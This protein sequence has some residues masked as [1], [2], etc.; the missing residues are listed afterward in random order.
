[1]IIYLNERIE[2]IYGEVAH[3]TVELRV[4]YLPSVPA[5]DYG[6]NFLNTLTQNLP[7]DLAAGFTTIGPHR[8]DFKVSFNS[9]EMMAVAS[10]GEVRTVVLAL[11]LAELHYSEEKSGQRPLLL[12]DDVFSE[13]DRERRTFL[14]DKLAGYQSV[15]TTTDAD[16][17][18]K[19]IR[20]PFSV[21]STGGI[22]A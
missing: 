15:I 11:K 5:S 21:I 14:I 12:L 2:G 1:M 8:E 3:G 22:Y 9:S 4:E 13:L 20:T 10:R 18:T 19:E 6:S 17:V 7:R 16:A